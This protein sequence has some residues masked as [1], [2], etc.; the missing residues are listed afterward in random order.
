MSMEEY[1]IPVSIFGDFENFLY[2]SN[3][4]LFPQIFHISCMKAEYTDI[5]ILQLNKFLV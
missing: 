1:S 4:S 2:P 5:I 3:V